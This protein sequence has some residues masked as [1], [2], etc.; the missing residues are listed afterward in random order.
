MSAAS[1]DESISCYI[2]EEAIACFDRLGRGLRTGESLIL[3]SSHGTDAVL[4][5]DTRKKILLASPKLQEYSEEYVVHGMIPEIDQDKLTC[6][7]LLFDGKKIT[8]PYN[9]Q[10]EQTVLDAVV[11]YRDKQTKV[12]L[13]GVGIVSRQGRLQKFESLE[14]IDILDPLDIFVQIESMR[15]LK[16]GWLEGAGKAPSESGLNWLAELLDRYLLDKTTPYLYPTNEGGVQVEWSL[17][18]WEAS[19]EI[20]I[21]LQSGYWHVLHIDSGISEEKDLNLKTHE[22]WEWIVTEILSKED[23]QI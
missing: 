3:S 23:I 12:M 1:K 11:G 18:G 9:A 2:S 4:T 8:V 13:K 19:L 6:R 16:D 7:L 17:N 5:R 21:D 10:H 22:A 15:H 14:S 20:D